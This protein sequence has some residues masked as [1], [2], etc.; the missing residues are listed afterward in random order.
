M[1]LVA[2]QLD[3]LGSVLT[4]AGEPPAAPSGGVTSFNG[5]TGAVT[6]YPT[7]RCDGVL[8]GAVQLSTLASASY[9]AGQ[10]AWVETLQ[11]EFVLEQT[12]VAAVALV[13]VAASGKSGYAWVRRLGR[14]P[15]WEAATTWFVAG[16]SGNDENAGTSAL[17]PLK[18]N[19]ELCRRLF[20]AQ[21]A[22]ASV[23]YQEN[24]TDALTLRCTATTS[25]TLQG[26]ET[27]LSTQVVTSAQAR[28]AAANQAN[29]ITVT[30]FDWSPYVGRL[31]RVQGTN[32]YAAIVKAPSL[33]VARLGQLY[34][35]ST[36]SQASSTGVAGGATVE[37]V[38]QTNGPNTFRADGR[39]SALLLVGLK[40]TATSI[41]VGTA[42]TAQVTAAKCVF[43]GASF[44]L[45]GLTNWTAQACLFT[46]PITTSKGFV[47]NV[48][49]CSFTSATASTSSSMVANFRDAT[50]QGGGLNALDGSLMYVKGDL[51]V[52]D[53]PAAATGLLASVGATI[54][55]SS[56]YYGSGNNATAVAITLST[57]G[58][59]AYGSKAALTVDTGVGVTTSAGNT[60]LAALP[61][62]LSGA[63]GTAV[64]GT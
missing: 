21:F 25:L 45:N 17:L 53:L 28:S 59:A 27:V 10:I 32:N 2:S 19:A 61:L 3:G 60:A 30:A 37:V 42:S 8:T 38:D 23:T 51:G 64:F 20:D 18:T 22:T 5:Q 15:A 11:A 34:N 41:N 29:E 55:I 63:N 35:W 16:T 1:S 39:I 40:S 36:G 44:I 47:S 9:A 26:T 12:S 33:G 46:A 54:N 52:F 56:G 57:M 58:R 62:A 50:C 13:V 24:T 49:G 48:T 6:Y 7:V 4:G 14:N 31:L 43:G